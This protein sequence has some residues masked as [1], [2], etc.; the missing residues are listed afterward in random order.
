[1]GKMWLQG[2][3]PKYSIALNT[4]PRATTD[5]MRQQ[6]MKQVERLYELE[7]EGSVA[8]GAAVAQR[9]LRTTAQADRHISPAIGGLRPS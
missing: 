1:M 4:Q 2:L 6:Y 8:A 5:W 7:R 3:H 9:A